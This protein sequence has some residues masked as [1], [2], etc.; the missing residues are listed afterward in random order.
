MSKASHYFV[1]PG[2]FH[3]SA[4]DLAFLSEEQYPVLSHFFKHSKC[5]KT[6]NMQLDDV[7]C[8]QLNSSDKVLPLVQ[9]FSSLNNALIATPIKLKADINSTWIQPAQIT[10]NTHQIMLDMAD[11]FVDDLSILKRIDEHYIIQ[12]KKTQVV[13]HLPHYL[14]VLGKKFDAYQQSIRAHLEWFKLVNEIQ[15]FLH[16]HALNQSA[17]G[18]P[19]MNS[20]WFWGGDSTLCLD[21]SKFIRSDDKLMQLALSRDRQQAQDRVIIKMDLV[22]YL[23]LNSELELDAFFYQFEQELKGLNLKKVCIDTADGQKF[24]FNSW[25]KLKFWQTKPSLLALLSQQLNELHI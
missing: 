10:S 17:H 9:Y 13:T 25:C 18:Q 24:V 14:T 16:G 21:H 20:L 22:K 1:I 23:K 12:F 19:F 3:L 4:A 6:Q 11:F 15:M 7:L 8:E 2:L 5:L